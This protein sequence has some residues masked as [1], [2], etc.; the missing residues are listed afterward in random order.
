MGVGGRGPRCLFTGAAA[1]AV[2][3]VKKD[4]GAGTGPALSGTNAKV[5][6]PFCLL[7]L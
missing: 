4:G 3:N 5:T 6:N 7:L 1:A 2:R